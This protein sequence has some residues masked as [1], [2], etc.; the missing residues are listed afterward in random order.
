MEVLL[1]SLPSFL[2]LLFSTFSHLSAF[3]GLSECARGPTLLDL[4]DIYESTVEEIS[5]FLLIS[6]IGSVSG[7]FASKKYT[8][9]FYAV[10][11][12]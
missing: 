6:S 2:A 9:I 4:T 1:L 7:C 10:F 8:H 3:Q 11:Q 5:I 12:Q